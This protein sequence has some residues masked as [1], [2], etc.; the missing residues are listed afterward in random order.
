MAIVESACSCLSAESVKAETLVRQRYL[1]LTGL[2]EWQTLQLLAQW[3][4]SSQVCTLSSTATSKD[5]EFLNLSVGKKKWSKEQK[6]KG[7]KTNQKEKRQKKIEKERE[8]RFRRLYLTVYQVLSSVCPSYKGHAPA[9]KRSSKVPGP[10]L[11]MSGWNRVKAFG[12]RYET[13]IVQSVMQHKETVRYSDRASHWTNWST[14]SHTT[15]QVDTCCPMLSYHL[16][17]W[18]G[19]ARYWVWPLLDTKLLAMDTSGF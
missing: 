7:N 16:M 3:E 18:N 6:K 8:A 4:K 14:H 15:L 12:T 5:H 17:H 19:R 11:S 2:E 9:T 10:A 1:I 13:K